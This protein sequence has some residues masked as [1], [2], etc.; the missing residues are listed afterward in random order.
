MDKDAEISFLKVT[1]RHLLNEVSAMS[2]QSLRREVVLAKL[3]AEALNL[4]RAQHLAERADPV[5]PARSEVY[6][7]D[8]RPELLVRRFKFGECHRALA[9]ELGVTTQQAE[10]WLRAAL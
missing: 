9:A 4:K 8:P 3:E 7:H 6:T 5:G 1:N 10:D 2:A